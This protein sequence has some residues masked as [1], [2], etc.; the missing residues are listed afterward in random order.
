MPGPTDGHTEPRSSA[1][2][3]AAYAASVTF[4]IPS[5]G[6]VWGAIFLHENIALPAGLGCAVIL[7]GTGFATGKIKGLPRGIKA[8][9]PP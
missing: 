4:L 3:R 9:K 7:L 1:N 8:P 6:V 2:T 5:F